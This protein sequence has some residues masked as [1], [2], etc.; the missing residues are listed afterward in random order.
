MDNDQTSSA[1][2]KQI[3]DHGILDFDQYSQELR[4]ASPKGQFIEYVAEQ[5]RNRTKAPQ[6]T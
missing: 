5:D 3:K 1:L 2:V 4:L 6:E